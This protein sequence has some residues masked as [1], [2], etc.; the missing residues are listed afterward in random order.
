MTQNYLAILSQCRKQCPNCQFVATTDLALEFH[1]EAEHHPEVQ[2]DCQVSGLSTSSN[3][4]QQDYLEEETGNDDFNVTGN[5]EGHEINVDNV[6]STYHQCQFCP[7][8]ANL[9]VTMLQHVINN[10]QD[11]TSDDEIQAPP[12]TYQGKL[13]CQ[14]CSFSALKNET[15][16]KHLVKKHGKSTELFSHSGNDQEGAPDP[17]EDLEKIEM[18]KKE[19]STKSKVRDEKT[20]KSTKL[21][22]QF[23]SFTSVGAQSME[24]HFKLRHSNRSKPNGSKDNDDVDPKKAETHFTAI[25][26]ETVEKHNRIIQGQGDSKISSEESPTPIED[27][28]NANLKHS[29]DRGS[30]GSIEMKPCSVNG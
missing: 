5:K 19:P 12:K 16:E 1:I 18:G 25:K 21:R 23:C 6:P 30:I 2:S 13:K 9:A 20:K 29:A 7:F 24:N 11:C 26:P 28:A 27:N 8:T 10:H 3:E 14:Y 22:C 4:V 15:M 17:S